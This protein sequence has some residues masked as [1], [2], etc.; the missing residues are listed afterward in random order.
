MFYLIQSTMWKV[1]KWEKT[2]EKN[3]TFE[4]QKFF[5]IN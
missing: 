1:N 3:K 4:K 2:F 5:K